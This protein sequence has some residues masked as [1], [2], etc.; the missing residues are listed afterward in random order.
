MNDKSNKISIIVA[1]FAV[2]LILGG[3][4]LLNESFNNSQ[5]TSLKQDSKDKTMTYSVVEEDVDSESEEKEE[6]F[7]TSKVDDKSDETK[8]VVKDQKQKQDKDEEEL[9]KAEEEK[10][11]EEELKKA[12]EEKKA[13]EAE[14][15]DNQM[16]VTIDS[17][18]GYNSTVS[19]VEC[20][21]P[22]ALAC[23]PGE[24]LQLRAL[25]EY[26]TITQGSNYKLSGNIYE[27]DGYIY[28]DT[29]DSVDLVK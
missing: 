14:L 15:E 13:A 22:N 18:D 24:V 8:K 17:T 9:K 5:P 28:I 21:V 10:K 6:L 16:I 12:E 26:A 4:Y 7:S 3:I 29:L 19:I 1:I 27:V 23:V 11:K 20:G 2:I 25:Q